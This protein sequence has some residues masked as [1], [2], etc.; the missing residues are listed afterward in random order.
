MGIFT[1]QFELNKVLTH[2]IINQFKEDTFSC[3]MGNCL[4]ATVLAPATH[5]FDG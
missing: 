4:P 3:N 5:Q 1:T 2:V